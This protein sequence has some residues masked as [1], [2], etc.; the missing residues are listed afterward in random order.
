V[1]TKKFEEP[2]FEAFNEEDEG[3]HPKTD[4]NKRSL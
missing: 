1:S 2:Y 3:E 4:K